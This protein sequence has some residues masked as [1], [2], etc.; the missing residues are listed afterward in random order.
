MRSLNSFFHAIDFALQKCKYEDIFLKVKQYKILDALMSG[1][2]VIGVLPTGYGKSIIF[3]LLPFLHEY[4]STTESNSIVIV[5][6]PLNALMNDQIKFLRSKG[7]SVGMFRTK[8]VQRNLTDE[9]K[10]DSDS[11][12]EENE[13]EC[14]DVG[15]EIFLVHQ[16]K[17]R[18]LFIH[19]EGF[20]SC[21]EGRKILLNDTYQKNVVCCIIDEAHLVQEWG[22]NFRLDFRHLCQLRAL[23]P[24]T[25]TLALTA[26]APPKNMSLLIS[27][28]QMQNPLKVIGNLDRQNIYI[29]V[30]K[31]KPSVFGSE[32]YEHILSP[33]AEELKTKQVNYPLTIIYLPLKWCGYAFKLFMQILQ[34]KSYF[35][36]D[37]REPSHC[38]FAQFHAAQTDKMKSEI[39]NQLTGACTLHNI[40]VVFATIALG[41][42]VN[43][44]DVRQVIHVGP[45][46]TIESYYQEIGRAGRD[47]QLA[48]SILYYN[49]SDIATNIPGMT[50]EMRAFC[51]TVKT[52]L[53]EYMLSYLG[54]TCQHKYLPHSCCTNCTVACNCQE[55]QD[56]LAA[57]LQLPQ[58]T[59]QNQ[60]RV[61]SLD[62][63]AKLISM[64]KNYRL[65]LGSK[66][67]R[68]GS[69]DLNTGFTLNLIDSIASQANMISSAEHMF[70]ICPMWNKEHAI[71]CMQMI[72][73]V[74]GE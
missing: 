29:E 36:T 25:P 70:E 56:I 24:C 40:R 51:S 55:C 9:T 2:D 53:R 17:F 46:R 20:I 48:K 22:E 18:I 54:S 5:V 64:M 6:A 42:G 26:S 19:P 10:Y 61:V 32:S 49:G 1:R 13:Y 7:V 45:P 57:Q 37:K 11:A 27:S 15:N 21:K 34:E 63:R 28:L 47:G 74:C 33:I 39:L 73:D 69:I 58:E 14:E 35:P 66:Y 72:K 38:L 52:C 30:L 62:E 43:I 16:G 8:P 12:S 44:P 67:C 3:Q 23:F 4:Y 41:L 50:D 59:K 31:R 60:V 65:E 68:F 71:A